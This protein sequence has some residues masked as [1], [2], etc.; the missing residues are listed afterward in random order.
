[1]SERLRWQG[2]TK[3]LPPELKCPK[4]PLLTMPIY[5]LL[6]ILV[7][8]TG[9]RFVAYPGRPTAIRLS[10]RLSAGALLRNGIIPHLM[11][12]LSQINWPSLLIPL[13]QKEISLVPVLSVLSLLRLFTVCKMSTSYSYPAVQ[14]KLNIH[15][16]DFKNNREKWTLVLE[17]FET[18]LQDVCNE[19]TA[20]SLARHQSRG[21][22]LRM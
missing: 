5:T 11:T 7:S 21:Q 13:C 19:G 6:S 8:C 22:L 15:D 14:S 3:I 16:Q 2:Y 10:V 17:R 12:W 9:L 4:D 18:A 1:M 20:A